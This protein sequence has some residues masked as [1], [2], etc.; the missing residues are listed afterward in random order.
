MWNYT[1]NECIFSLGHTSVLCV[2]SAHLTPIITESE[3]AIFPIQ[4]NSVDINGE[5]PTRFECSFTS[6]PL[7]SSVVSH[8]PPSFRVCFYIFSTRFECI[9]MCRRGFVWIERLPNLS[10]HGQSDCYLVAKC[11]S[12]TGLNW[13]NLHSKRV[14]KIQNTLET[15]GEDVKTHSKRVEKIGSLGKNSHSQSIIELIDLL[16][17]EKASLPNTGTR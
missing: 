10:A 7:V 17:V 8:L 12:R 15:S 13:W 6:S 9:F 5:F 3:T 2:V 4:V 16:T 14:E 11:N 1:R